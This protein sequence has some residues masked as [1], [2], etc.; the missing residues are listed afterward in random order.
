ML[1]QIALT[2][3]CVQVCEVQNIKCA[4]SEV[5]SAPCK[6]MISTQSKSCNIFTKFTFDKM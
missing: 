6:C 5:H 4:N 1:S 2:F 3:Y